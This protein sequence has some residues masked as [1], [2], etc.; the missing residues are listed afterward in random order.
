MR[1]LALLPAAWLL[2]VL[3]LG[4]AAAAPAALAFPALAP[5]P[6]TSDHLLLLGATGNPASCVATA[7]GSCSTGLHLSLALGSVGFPIHQPSYTGTGEARLTWLLPFAGAMLPVGYQT[8]RCG[9]VDGVFQD[10]CTFSE[11]M[12]LP[13]LLNSPP[14]GTL[15]EH[16]CHSFEL[17]SRT[18][19]GSGDVRCF[20]WHV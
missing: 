14:P 9:W 20:V 13:A 16:T 12:M 2:V 7:P 6:A 5:G 19:G 10:D 11:G 4:G 1:A 8:Y 15:Y 18:P 3:A 17:G